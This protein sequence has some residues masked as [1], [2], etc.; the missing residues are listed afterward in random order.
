MA[1]VEDEQL[2]TVTASGAVTLWNWRA[3]RRL[4]QRTFHTSQHA[5]VTAAR[6]TGDGTEI[7]AL[8]DSQRLHL[9]ALK[10]ETT[11]ELR[12]HEDLYTFAMVP[13]S[14][15][16]TTNGAGWT[17]ALFDRD[18]RQLQARLPATDNLLV[19]MAFSPDGRR[20]AIGDASGRVRVMR[21]SAGRPILDLPPPRCTA[22]AVSPDGLV[23]AGGS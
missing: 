10:T 23:L 7:V 4:H 17:T 8:P 15:L 6:I 14:R 21:W 11:E 2:L 12:S 5:R 16:L 13:S 22:L 3:P 18:T 20:L 19:R 9:H 1:F